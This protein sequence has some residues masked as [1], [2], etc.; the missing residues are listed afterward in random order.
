MTEIVYV[1]MFVI[2]SVLGLRGSVRVTRRFRAASANN[3]MTAPERLLLGV[4]VVVCWTITAAAL[5]LGFLSVRRLLGFE[6]LGF[7]APVSFVV[8]LGVL[9]LPA[10]ID[11][12]ITK[13]A[14][15]GLT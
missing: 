14:K 13:I 1:L 9:L 11:A 3:A 5:Y 7:L 10:A 12:V 8:A 15:W 4:L 2:A 6:A